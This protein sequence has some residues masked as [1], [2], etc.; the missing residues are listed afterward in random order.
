LTTNQALRHYKTQAALARALGIQ[1]QSIDVWGD[2]PPLL[3]QI[4]L[5]RL[6]GGQLRANAEAWGAAHEARTEAP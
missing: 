5:E 3:R 1:R 2:E 4:Q 6:T